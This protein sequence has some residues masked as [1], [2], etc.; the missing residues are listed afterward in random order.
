MGLPVFE[1]PDLSFG[2]V[3]PD[4]IRF[5]DFPSVLIALGSNHVEMVVGELAPRS[6]HFAF[7]LLPV[8]RN[9]I[10]IHNNLL[11]AR[12]RQSIGD[13]GD[14]SSAIPVPVYLPACN[15]WVSLYLAVLGCKCSKQG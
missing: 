14:R 7:V 1:G 11:N 8:T 4:A 6:I 9:R 3:L 13:C 12:P 10:P 5:P 2:L 15:Q